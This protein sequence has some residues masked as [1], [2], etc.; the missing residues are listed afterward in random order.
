VRVRAN[1]AISPPCRARRRRARGRFLARDRQRTARDASR[2]EEPPTSIR[3]PRV[4]RASSARR[5]PRPGT[6]RRPRP[7]APY[8]LER[9]GPSRP[10]SQHSRMLLTIPRPGRRFALRRAAAAFR[11][12]AAG[13]RARRFLLMRQQAVDFMPGRHCLRRLDW[14]WRLPAR[15]GTFS[16]TTRSARCYRRLASTARST[17]LP[18]C[19]ARAVPPTLRKTPATLAA[20]Y[21]RR[22]GPFVARGEGGVTRPIHASTSDRGATVWWMSHSPI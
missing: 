3:G 21:C 20:P 4:P 5:V 13:R 12:R 8:A 14:R 19:R 6:A 10:R 15:D 11:R 7:L 16:A 22:G 2:F 9:A 17:V 1:Y 18:S